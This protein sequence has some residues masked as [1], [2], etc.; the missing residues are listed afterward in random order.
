MES[1]SSKTEQSSS[2]Y[3]RQI[4]YALAG[5]ALSALPNKMETMEFQPDTNWY[6]GLQR[7]EEVVRTEQNEQSFLYLH[8]QQTGDWFAEQEHGTKAGH[9]NIDDEFS[10]IGS[11]QAP[12]HIER[13]CH[14]HTHPEKNADI[15]PGPSHADVSELSKVVNYVST[16]QVEHPDAFS[17]TVDVIGMVADQYGIW[18]YQDYDKQLVDNL[19]D[20]HTAAEQQTLLHGLTNWVDQQKAAEQ[21]S[22]T[23]SQLKTLLLEQNVDVDKLSSEEV[24]RFLWGQTDFR[25]QFNYIELGTGL[26]FILDNAPEGEHILSLIKPIAHKSNAVR[27][28]M[29]PLATETTGDTY[30][31]TDEAKAKYMKTRFPDFAKAFLQYRGTRVNFL[32]Y[33]EAQVAPPC[34]PIDYQPPSP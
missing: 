9:I 28:A 20:Q 15:L 22:A 3:R 7:I 2:K 26:Q 24:A 14:G 4:L 17:D 33:E 19:I 6:S 31:L 16:L 5:A 27:D 32:T 1:F 11:G 23:F 21:R 34:P 8:S 29:T 10:S 18:Y 13:I 25:L 12:E 30:G